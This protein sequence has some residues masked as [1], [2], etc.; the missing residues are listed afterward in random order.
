M[1]QITYSSLYGPF[2]MKM[3]PLPPNFPE[4]PYFSLSHLSVTIYILP[5]CYEL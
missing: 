1:P 5:E 3:K 2:I 4:K